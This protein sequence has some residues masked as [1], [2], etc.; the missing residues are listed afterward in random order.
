[1]CDAP[2]RAAM[3]LC[4]VMISIADGQLPDEVPLEEAACVGAA[5]ELARILLEPAQPRARPP[6][7]RSAVVC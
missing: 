2:E 1:M 6:R 5:D 4:E 7:S 3:A